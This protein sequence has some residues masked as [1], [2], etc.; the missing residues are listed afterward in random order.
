MDQKDYEEFVGGIIVTVAIVLL[1][2]SITG[3]ILFGST[4]LPDGR[5]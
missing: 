3:A 4:L 5:G 2:L 1:A